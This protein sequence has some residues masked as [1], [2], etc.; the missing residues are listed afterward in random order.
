MQYNGYELQIT[1]SGCIIRDSLGNYIDSVSDEGDAKEY[2]DDLVAEDEEE[3]KTQIKTTTKDWYGRFEK[4]C[5]HLPGKIY[6][7][8]EDKFGTC[9]E[10]ALKKHI[11]SFEENTGTRVMF[12]L[13]S[14]CGEHFFIVDSVEET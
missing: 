13:R 12:S 14:M 7:S 3:Q 5:K 4:Y 8:D 6:L 2:I 1:E 10:A 11:K 9:F